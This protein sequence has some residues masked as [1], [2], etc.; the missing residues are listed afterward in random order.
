MSIGHSLQCCEANLTGQQ[1][2]Y[3]QAF[4][5]QGI[6]FVNLPCL[7]VTLV[8]SYRVP[9][10]KL[11]IYAFLYTLGRLQ[12]SKFLYDFFKCPQ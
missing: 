1:F 10:L 8:P 12:S 4:L 3:M 9:T 2:Q 6:L 5:G 11:S 7:E